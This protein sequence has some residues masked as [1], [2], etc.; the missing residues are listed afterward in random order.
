[1]TNRLPWMLK[2][3]LA[4]AIGLALSTSFIVAVVAPVMGQENPPSDQTGGNNNVPKVC[5]PLPAPSSLTL[6]SGNA[7]FSASWSAVTNTFG[8]DVGLPG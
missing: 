7:Q 3:W 8:G 2:T 1:M 6:T 4:V 5:S